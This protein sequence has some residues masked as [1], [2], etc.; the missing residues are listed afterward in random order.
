VWEFRGSGGRGGF[1]VFSHVREFVESVKF[2]LGSGSRGGVS[3]LRETAT[4]CGDR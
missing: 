4:A 1:I 3:G 2:F